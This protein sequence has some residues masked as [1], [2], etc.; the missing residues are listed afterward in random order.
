MRE[1]LVLEAIAVGHDLTRGT[2]RFS[3]VERATQQPP[4][5]DPSVFND[6]EGTDGPGEP[7]SQTDDKSAAA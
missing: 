1:K 3:R 5:D 2:T 6:L 4:A 7:A